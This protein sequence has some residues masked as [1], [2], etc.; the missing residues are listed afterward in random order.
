[1]SHFSFDD[2]IGATSLITSVRSSRLAREVK[3]SVIDVGR[4]LGC[5]A[6]IVVLVMQ[7]LT[8]VW[9]IVRNTMALQYHGESSTVCSKDYY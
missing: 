8:L 6:P 7:F 2:P 4:V 3:Y 1:M 5:V 9:T